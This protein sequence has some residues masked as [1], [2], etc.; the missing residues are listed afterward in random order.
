M[1]AAPFGRRTAPVMANEALGGYRLLSAL[2]ET[3]PPPRPGQFY[4]LSTAERWGADG[5]R[6]YLPRA[7]SYARARE[8]SGGVRLDFLLEAV[9]PGTERL[10][11]VGPGEGLRLVGPL[12]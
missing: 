5:E 4:M 2:D 7:F 1:T 6:P 12:G 3:G 10:A 8:E 11:E 9:G